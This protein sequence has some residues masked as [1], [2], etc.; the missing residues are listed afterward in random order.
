MTHIFVMWT[1]KADQYLLGAHHFVGFA[2]LLLKNQPVS[3]KQAQ[4]SNNMK[5]V[6]HL[7]NVFI[8]FERHICLPENA[9]LHDYNMIKLIL[10]LNIK[11]FS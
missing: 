5:T 4:Y 8:F 7:K 1:G 9:S 6:Q 3:Q 2:V 10:L 11:L